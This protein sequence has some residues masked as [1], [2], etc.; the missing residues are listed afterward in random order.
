MGGITASIMS[1]KRDYN[2]LEHIAKSSSKEE[3]EKIE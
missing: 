2:S 1:V 3:V